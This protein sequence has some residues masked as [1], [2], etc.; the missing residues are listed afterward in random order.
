[1][2]EL[3]TTEQRLIEFAREEFSEFLTRF[4]LAGLGEESTGRKWK[5]N[6][7]YAGEGKSLKRQ[8]QALSHEPED[9]T[10]LLPRRRNPLVLLALLR[11]R[12][13]EA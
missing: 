2:L 3:S 1:M 5:I 8:V 7:N 10:A 9:G 11:R 4:L 13:A 6:I 12:C